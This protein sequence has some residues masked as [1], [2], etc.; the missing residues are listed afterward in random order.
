M[1][2]GKF[3]LALTGVLIVLAGCD[4]PETGDGLKKI[5]GS[6]HVAAGTAPQAASTV[7]GDIHIDDN[8]AVTEANT[9]NGGIQLG[10]NATAGTLNT[11]NGGI[12]VGSNSHVAKDAASVN[13]SLTLRD[14]AD[15]LGS[16]SNVNGKIE[17]SA[18]HVGGDIKTVAG[19]I[20]IHGPS[21]VDGGILVEKGNQVIHFGSGIPRVE[22]GPGAT[23][24]GALRFEREVKLY[25]SDKA[26]IGP[27]TGATPIPFTGDTA[28]A[29]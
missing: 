24:Q 26:T 29:G 10:S 5:N 17:L 3:M 22:I 14:G 25:V 2:S 20:A 27:I 8:A 18:A 15:V 23:V 9:V 12:T 4:G 7:N 6:V 1:I 11:V 16:V 13:G 21:H 28:P 19:D